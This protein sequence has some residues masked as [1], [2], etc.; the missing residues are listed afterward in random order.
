MIDDLDE[1]GRMKL[2]FAANQRAERNA[3]HGLG[4]F[5]RRFGE[6]IRHMGQ[7]AGGVGLP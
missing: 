6:P 5:L 4:R 2:E 7:Q 3:V 1:L